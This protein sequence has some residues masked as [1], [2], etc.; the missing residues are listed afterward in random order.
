MGQKQLAIASVLIVLL[1]TVTQAVAGIYKLIDEN[2]HVTYTNAAAKGGQKLRVDP[3]GPRV[4]A[5]AM[6]TAPLAIRGFPKVS[7]NQQKKRDVNRR[8]ILENELAAETK[9]LAEMQQVLNEATK[10]LR[11]V[12]ANHAQLL[13]DTHVS[14]D[15]SIKKLRNQITLHERN[16]T[17]LRIELGNH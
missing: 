3:A 4:V 6:T 16:I 17:A 2:G 15:E 14:E 9:L 7:D 11:R 5:K 13:P 8:Q 12:A 1:T 10:N